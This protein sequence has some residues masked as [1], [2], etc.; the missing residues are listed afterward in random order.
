[1]GETKENSTMAMIIIVVEG[2]EPFEY[3]PDD[4]LTGGA[5]KKKHT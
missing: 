5:V 4:A 3:T 2:F 1:M